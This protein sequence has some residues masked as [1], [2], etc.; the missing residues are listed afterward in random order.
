MRD[1]WCAYVDRQALEA[2]NAAMG[3]NSEQLYQVVKNLASKQSKGFK[4]TRIRLEDGTL[5]SQ[6]EEAQARWL[7][8]HA[9]NFNAKIQSQQEYNV[10]LLRH[11]LSKSPYVS[12][13][14]SAF[15]YMTW[16]QDFR[17]ILSRLKNRKAAG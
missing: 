6:Y 5:A 3:H 7:R 2:Q 13:A 12:D 9:G 11:R 14:L 17:D 8:F 1:D 15:E 16:H 4:F 10:T